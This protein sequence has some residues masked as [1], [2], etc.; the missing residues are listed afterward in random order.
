METCPVYEV[1]P[2]KY[3]TENV[4]KI[5]LNPKIEEHKVS[6]QCPLHIETS[7]TFVIS[8]SS[9]KDQDDVK[10]DNFGVWHHSGSHSLTFECC[11]TTNG[12]VR[13]GRSATDIP[14]GQWKKYSL[15]RLHSK[16]PTNNKFK[17]MIC[18]LTGECQ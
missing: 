5:L 18:F 15:R 6:K 11:I 10:K 8:L 14:Q 3:A 17:R 1:P 13:V 9:L 12:E 2:E 4:I 7:S 16:H